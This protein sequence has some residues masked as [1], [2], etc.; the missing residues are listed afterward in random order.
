MLSNPHPVDATFFR[1]YGLH[2]IK[3]KNDNPDFI[4][5]SP[6]WDGTTELLR[7][8]FPQSGNVIT[9]EYATISSDLDILHKDRGLIAQRIQ[10]AIDITK[11]SDA[12]LHLGTPTE[13]YDRTGRPRWL[14]SVLSIRRGKIESTTHKTTLVPL[15]EKAG[16]IEPLV[17]LRRIKDGNAVLICA[18]LY[19]LFIGNKGLGP[20]QNGGVKR[21]FAPASWAT[22]IVSHPNTHTM[23]EQAGGEDNYYRKQ[24]ELVVAKYV[25]TIPTV[26]Q[27]IVADKGRPD[28]APYNAVFNRV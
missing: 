7:R 4:A 8:H 21:I 22:P 27:V 24:L 14:N 9:P 11:H 12:V 26:R 15:E 16:V 19:G 23:H 2:E 6:N 3:N 10:E 25:M 17:D 13:T 18:E 1:D 20:L 5:S 28:L